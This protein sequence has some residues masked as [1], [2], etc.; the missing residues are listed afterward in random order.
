MSW[1]DHVT[2]LR[3][4]NVIWLASLLATALPPTD[5]LLRLVVKLVEI[6]CA[7]LSADDFYSVGTNHGFDQAYALYFL[8]AALPISDSVREAKGVAR[9]RLVYELNVAFN[10]E[11]V[12]IENSPSYHATMLMRLL[13]AQA[14]LRA[15]DRAELVGVASTIEKA[16]TFLSHALKP[17]GC[18]PLLGDTE[19][20]PLRLEL[21][22]LKDFQGFAHLCHAYSAGKEGIE[23]PSTSACYPKAGYAFL[24]DRWPTAGKDD[25]WHLA[26][27]CGF[28]STYHRHD[29]DNTLLVFAFGEDWLIGSGIYKYHE[30]DPLRKYL[31]SPEAQNILTVEGALADRNVKEARSSISSFSTK[32]GVTSLRASSN[33]YPGFVYER[34]LVYDRGASTIDLLDVMEPAAGGRND[35]VLRFLVPK[36]RK[37]SV[38]SPSAVRVTSERSGKSMLIEIQSEAPDIVDVVSGQAEPPLGWTSPQ[39]GVIEPAQT[40]CFKS[41]AEGR[42]EMASRITFG[43]APTGTR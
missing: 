39:R 31:R 36:D 37:I 7:V 8:T 12:H 3:A 35:F 25:G 38:L 29:D 14:L 40:I 18:L 33:M 26:L 17:N 42:F 43:E 11:G 20:L 32:N 13:R 23:P 4:I 28:L 6:H 27:K 41:S 30:Q 34:R 9:A 2:A 10:E 24:R 5:E 16:M 1:H 21:D 19:A 22:A 15:F